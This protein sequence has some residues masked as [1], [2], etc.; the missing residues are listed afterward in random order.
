M[1]APLPTSRATHHQAVLSGCVQAATTF[2]ESKLYDV[3]ACGIMLF[4]MLTGSSPFNLDDVRASSSQPLPG[5]STA[6][7]FEWPKS[8][9]PSLSCQDLVEQMLEP[10]PLKR[11]SID[12]VQRHAWYQCDLPRELQ[13]CLHPSCLSLLASKTGTE[14][15]RCFVAFFNSLPLL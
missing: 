1:K 7:S 5:T 14:I 10:D 15:G 8:C 13:V 3:F 6:L 11:I 4:T 2:Q 9:L 12:D